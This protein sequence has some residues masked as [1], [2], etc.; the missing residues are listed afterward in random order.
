MNRQHAAINT[1]QPVILVETDD[2]RDA[3]FHAVRSAAVAAAR[4]L[5][6]TIV[7][8][9][10]SS[11]S[12]WTDPYPAGPMTAEVDGPRGDRPL[13]ADELEPLGRGYL[14]AQIA[15]VAQAGVRAHAWLARD[16][17]PRDLADAMARSG[18]GLAFLAERAD[19]SLMD[20][21]RHRTVA[22]YAT[23]LAGR[24]VLVVPNT[25]DA[26]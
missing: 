6:A 1:H 24:L 11:G 10:R 2:G 26:A 8:L 14:T 7:L 23:R 16:G 5:G 4:R 13:A 17:G 20:R 19:A 9:D 18:A 12:P 22:D 21:L 15:E 25:V 3:R